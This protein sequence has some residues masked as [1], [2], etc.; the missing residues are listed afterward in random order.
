MRWPWQRRLPA[1]VVL[2][3]DK[4]LIELYSTAQRTADLEVEIR[5]ARTRAAQATA[6]L[7]IDETQIEGH[8]RLPQNAAAALLEDLPLTADG[9]LHDAAFDA[10]LEQLVWREREQPILQLLKTGDH[11]GPD[12]R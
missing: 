12:A 4:R 1:G 2:I 11:G 7:K 3:D 9:R 5:R 10:L 6:E 8:V